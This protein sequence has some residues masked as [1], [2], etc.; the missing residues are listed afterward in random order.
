MSVV[1][2]LID[3]KIQIGEHSVSVLRSCRRPA[4]GLLP[5]PVAPRPRLASYQIGSVTHSFAYDLADRP[6]HLHA[7]AS[8]GALDLTFTYDAVGNVRTIADPRP[9][10][11][12]LFT[13][14]ALESS[15]YSDAAVLP[16]SGLRIV[17]DIRLEV[18][19]LLTVSPAALRGSYVELKVKESLKV[20]WLTASTCRQTR[21]YWRSR[22]PSIQ[23][24]GPCRR[25]GLMFRLSR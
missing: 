20:P 14:A 18:T 22:R 13:V 21:P 23:G 8:G 9:G 15:G 25:T 7:V 4:A 16:C 5:G 24:A 12:Q 1:Q 6:A 17:D 19:P 11:T 10:A 3:T 2:K